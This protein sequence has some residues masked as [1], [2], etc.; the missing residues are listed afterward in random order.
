MKVEPKLTGL[1]FIL[2]LKRVGFLV[3]KSAIKF[4]IIRHIY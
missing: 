2:L 4:V 3:I 1:A